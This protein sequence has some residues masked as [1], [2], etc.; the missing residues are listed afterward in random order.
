MEE[1]LFLE[2]FSHLK[3]MDNF[4]LTM[5]A[6]IGRNI[7]DIAVLLVTSVSRDVMVERHITTP[8][9]GQPSKKLSASPINLDKP[10]TYLNR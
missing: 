5:R 9:T 6:T 8:H 1:Q 3:C 4:W 10:D 7:V 2:L